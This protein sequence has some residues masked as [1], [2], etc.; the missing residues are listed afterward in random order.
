MVA[1]FVR[2]EGAA[3]SNPVIPILKCRRTNYLSL[4]TNSCRFPADLLTLKAMEYLLSVGLSFEVARET[5]RS[6]Q[7]TR[8]WVLYQLFESGSCKALYDMAEFAAAETVPS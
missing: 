1:H 8:A 2:D 6:A 4:V 3:G 5:H 7:G